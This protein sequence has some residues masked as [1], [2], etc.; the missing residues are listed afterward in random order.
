MRSALELK[1]LSK[2]PTKRIGLIVVALFTLLVLVGCNQKSELPVETKLD[3]K[4]I[5]TDGTG[6]WHLTLT[7]DDSLASTNK[8]AAEQSGQLLQTIVPIV[9]STDGTASIVINEVEFT[10]KVNKDQIKLMRPDEEDVIII[11]KTITETTIKGFSTNN[12]DD[13]PKNM[14]V[15]LNKIIN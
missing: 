8:E 7:N 15:T 10:Y 9:F 1:K 11:A 5:L 14:S 2:T 13:M 4:S 6:E 12:S 3:L